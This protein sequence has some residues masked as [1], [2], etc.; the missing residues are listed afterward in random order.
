MTTAA[1]RLP[2]LMGKITVQLHV[3]RRCI[4]CLSVDRPLLSLHQG[5]PTL[6]SYFKFP[7]N[8]RF[9]NFFVHLWFHSD[10]ISLAKV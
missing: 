3:Q 6:N 4:Y 5:F 2:R 8:N 7:T 10:G 1:A 9:L